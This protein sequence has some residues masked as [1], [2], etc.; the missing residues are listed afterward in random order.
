VP[1]PTSQEYNEAVQ[2]PQASF[3]DE[4]LK[5]GRAVVNPL[6]IPLPRSGNF[7]DVY[8]LHCPGGGCWA[9][10]CFTREVAGLRERYAEISRHLRHAALRFSVD[11]T[12]LEPGIRI[13]GRWYPVLKMQWVE[14]LTLHEFAG[15]YA[16][17]PSML[18]GLL[19]VWA[20]MA[21]RLR[22]A[23]VGHGDLQHGNVLLVPGRDEKHLAVKLIDYD[24]MYVPALASRP[25]GEVGHPCYQHPQRVREKAYGPEVDRFPLLLVATALACLKAAGRPLWEKYDTGDNL[26]FRE[27]DLQTPVKSPLF[28]ELLKV[29]DW[30]AR[31]LV[32]QTIDAL[33]GPLES[34][35]LLA[36][37]LPEWQAAES[38]RG[39]KAAARAQPSAEPWEEDPGTAA[40]AA[41]LCEDAARHKRKKSRTGVWVLAGV[42]AAALG[43]G[44]AVGLYL[45]ADQAFGPPSDTNP[46]VAPQH[47]GGN[48]PPRT[49][50]SKVQ[51][52]RKDEQPAPASAKDT[53]AV[54]R[55]KLKHADPVVQEGAADGLAAHGAAA[56][57]A[58]D[59]LA[60]VL[61]DS[62]VPAVRRKA[63]IALARVLA[64]SKV[65]ADRCHAASALTKVSKDAKPDAKPAVPA[66]AGA[67]RSSERV[68]RRQAA[69]ALR[70][71]GL[72]H[73]DAAV[74]ALLESIQK[75]PDA[76]V[77]QECVWSL[78]QY[79]QLDTEGRKMLLDQARPI[80][81]AVLQEEKVASSDTLRYNTAC[82]LAHAFHDDAP[83]RTVEVL[84]EALARK[85]LLEPTSRGDARF[86][87]AAALGWLGKTS[88]QRKDVVDALKAAAADKDPKLSEAARASLTT[89]GVR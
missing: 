80:L 65:P 75:D 52:T 5:S 12:F 37:V 31:K 81:A 36:E 15:R 62:K 29:E 60:R 1:W 54:L 4:E 6:G 30:R 61:A 88:S 63:A 76:G 28:A 84:L 53:V 23:G 85:D 17:R 22:G 67:L 3:S 71:I 66:L 38:A 7:A 86:M 33:R 50:P 18:E 57:P 42:A 55:E 78:F 73:T 10:K 70:L 59:D 72:P 69:E 68:V 77:R 14:G 41:R 32:G 82:L 9:V 26:L 13:H 40:S 89:L 25:S 16:D 87:H 46:A 56:A 49:E 34:V 47:D 43:V 51:D 8:E 48:G 27:A 24:G 19:R 35:P 39:A 44:I 64:D 2:C 79:E 21:E 20:R 45:L 58:I 11:F 83:D 74:P